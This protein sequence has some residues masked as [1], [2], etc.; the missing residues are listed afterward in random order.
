MNPD[1][2]IDELLSA[3]CVRV[4]WLEQAATRGAGE[5]SSCDGRSFG[6]HVRSGNTAA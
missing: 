1:L 2:Q 6:R 4:W 3:R 5:D